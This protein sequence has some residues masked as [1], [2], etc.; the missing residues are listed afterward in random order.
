LRKGSSCAYCGAAATTRDHIPPVKLF[1]RPRSSDLVTVPACESCNNDAS[2]NNEYFVWAVTMNVKSGSESERVVQQRLAEPVTARRRRTIEQLKRSM[3]PVDV[4]SPGGVYLG[5]AMGYDADR[6]RLNAVIE[7]CVRGLYFRE[8]KHRV[9]EDLTVVGMIDPPPRSAHEPAVR[10]LVNNPLKQSGDGIFQYWI[11]KVEP[12]E[13]EGVALCLM[14]FFQGLLAVGFVL[15]SDTV[16]K[17]T[18]VQ[19]AGRRH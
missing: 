4:M 10:A 7:R 6:P 16:E 12:E 15:P 18:M 17:A 14:R 1:P 8:F 11:K 3:R 19:P 9:A 5:Q 2:V 13:P